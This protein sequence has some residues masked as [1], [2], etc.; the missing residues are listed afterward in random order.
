MTISAKQQN[1][2]P[3]QRRRTATLAM[4]IA[5]ATLATLALVALVAAMALA[6]STLTIGSASNATLGEQVVV[7]SQGHTLYALSPE[8]AG[9][10]LCKSSA[11]LKVWPPLTVH[12]RTTKLKDGAGVKGRL[13]ILHRSDGMLQVVLA[14]RPLYRF[15]G[16]SAKGQAN[17]QGL[18]SFGGTWHAVTASGPSTPVTA[19]TPPAM[20]APPATPGYGY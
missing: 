17:G 7:N 9:H 18:E 6:A 5:A 1:V 10:L 15:S 19:P 16:D 20:P 11:C 4:P 14:G 8:T 13:T 2:E 3:P 12:S